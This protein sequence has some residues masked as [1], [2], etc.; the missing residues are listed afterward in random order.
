[1]LSCT[2]DLRSESSVLISFYDMVLVAPDAGLIE[3]VRLLVKMDSYILT[4]E[5]TDLNYSA[6]RGKADLLRTPLII[7][8]MSAAIVNTPPIMYEIFMSRLR[9][10]GVD[11]IYVV[12]T[13]Q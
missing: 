6:P 7:T 3:V 4:S 2:D 10:K 1:M 5:K 9:P 12:T 11:S 8:A 13:K